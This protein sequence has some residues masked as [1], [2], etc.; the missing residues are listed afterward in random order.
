MKSNDNLRSDS[1]I[2]LNGISSTSSIFQTRPWINRR[3]KNERKRIIVISKV[4]RN[5]VTL[6]A[7]RN[8]N[9][10][11]LAFPM[12]NIVSPSSFDLKYYYA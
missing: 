11:V 6:S 1:G 3:P 10:E 9:P 8:H 2:Q 12:N 5:H 4:G 7:G